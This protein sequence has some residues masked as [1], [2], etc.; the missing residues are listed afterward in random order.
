[1]DERG[2]RQSR[3]AVDGPGFSFRAE[4]PA[5][6]KKLQRIMSPA[7]RL[8]RRQLLLSLSARLGV[9]GVLAERF[10]LDFKH[11]LQKLLPVIHWFT[12]QGWFQPFEISLLS[13]AEIQARANVLPAP[14]IATDIWEEDVLDFA[15]TEESAYLSLRGVSHSA[16]A[17]ILGAQA[18]SL[19]AS[20]STTDVVSLSLKAPTKEAFDRLGPCA[21]LSAFRKSNT[22]RDSILEFCQAGSKLNALKSIRLSLPS[23]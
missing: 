12:F 3:F 21:R 1:M 2:H 5:P 17:I 23:S 4:F 20:T 11:A 6:S 8:V 19:A 22:P 14:S 7:S 16:E 9:L 13:F 10:K 15:S 18:S